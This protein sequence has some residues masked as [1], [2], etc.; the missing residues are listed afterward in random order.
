MV[1]YSDYNKI[2][3]VENTILTVGTFDGIHL[4]HQKIIKTL[5]EK[6]KANNMRELVITFEPHPRKI[7]GKDN[8]IKILTTLDEKIE[9]LSKLGVNNLLVINFTKEFSQLT[10]DKFF[11]NIIIDKIGLKEIIIGHDHKFGKDRNGD[12]AKVSEIGKDFNFN[13]TPVEAVKIDSLTISSTLIRNCLLKGNVK[14]ANKYIG[15]NYSLTGVVVTGDKRGKSLGYPTA[16][17]QT[18]NDDKMLPG[19]GIYAV[20]VQWNSLNLKGVMSIG[21][22]PTFKDSNQIVVEV[23][24]FD[25]DKNIYGEKLKVEVIERIREEKKF[26]SVDEL[27]KEIKIDI[28][29]SLEILK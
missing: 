10:A 26:S 17:I 22:R 23:Y 7:V 29:K 19:I 3:R 24:I 1:V 8:S 5:V 14:D 6:S 13:V 18:D 27:I 9:L 16:N 4:G 15:R 25:F 11:Q 28:K 21:M 12:E 2:T 20:K